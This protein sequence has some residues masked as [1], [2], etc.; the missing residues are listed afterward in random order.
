MLQDFP[1]LPPLPD[2]YAKFYL[3]MLPI[4]P[5][6]MLLSFPDSINNQFCPILLPIS[7]DHML[8]VLPDHMLSVLSDLVLSVLPDLM[9]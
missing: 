6:R 1:V 3:I 5:D 9:L 7:T 4:L 8:P 2:Y